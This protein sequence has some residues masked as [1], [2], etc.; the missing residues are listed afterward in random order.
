[1]RNIYLCGLGALGTIYAKALAPFGLRVVADAA[2]AARYRAEGVRVNGEEVALSYLTPGENAPP[3]DLVIVAVK[4]QNLPEAIESLRPFVGPETVILS[5]MNGIESE[6]VLGRAFGMEKLLYAFVVEVDAVRQGQEVRYSKAGTIVFGEARNETI[7]PRVAAV[8][9]LFTKGGIACR[10]PQDM[11]RELWWKFM[12]NVGVNQL[13]AVLRMSYGAFAGETLRGLVREA[14]GEVVSI[15]QAKGIGLTGADVEAIFPILAR[16]A[17][18][19]KTSMLQD[20]EAGRQTENGML[21]E[22]VLAM[23]QELGIPTPVNEM[24]VRLVKV[25]DEKL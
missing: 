3:A 22:S 13:S 23:G 14:C 17:P 20:V 9:E 24:L 8:K 7:S 16:L 5:L 4:W 25:L 10:V 15:A 1:M 2:R 18:E 6:I 19:Q 21:G 11:L 12:L